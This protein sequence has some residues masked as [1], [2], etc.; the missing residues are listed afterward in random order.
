MRSA[1]GSPD[2]LTAG[3]IIAAVVAVLVAV[4]YAFLR[5][6]ASSYAASAPPPLRAGHLAHNLQPELDMLAPVRQHAREE[7]Y[8]A[9]HQR[10]VLDAKVR[11]AKAAAQQAAVQKQ[12]TVLTFSSSAMAPAGYGQ[13]DSYTAEIP[14]GSYMACVA[15]AE[16]SDSPNGYPTGM[17]G[18]LG[19]TWSW[20]ETVPGSPIYGSSTGDAG[21]ASL[22]TQIQAF[23]FEYNRFGH[24]AWPDGC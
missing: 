6:P 3:L 4:A 15:W 7:V 5:V 19:S 16:S 2:R 13:P 1:E 24:S 17:F 18:F 21:A 12:A 9:W 8:S 14:R 11:A 20:L 10:V 23:I 22:A